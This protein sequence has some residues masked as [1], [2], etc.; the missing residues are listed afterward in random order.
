M[1]GSGLGLLDV[2]HELPEGLVGAVP[3]QGLAWPVVHQ[4][5]DGV[6]HVLVMHRQVSALGQELAQQAVGVLA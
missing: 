3:V 1:D 2:P 4:I 5:C 6:Q